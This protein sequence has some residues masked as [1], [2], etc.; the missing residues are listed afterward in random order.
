MKR[1]RIVEKSAKQFYSNLL[2]GLKEMIE[3]GVI[4][5][6]TTV[7]I[8]LTICRNYIT[9]NSFRKDDRM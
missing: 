7:D 5:E 8:V 6:D 3:E 9:E 2:N 4:S 1:K